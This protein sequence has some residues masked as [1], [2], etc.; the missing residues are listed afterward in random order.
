VAEAIHADLVIISRGH[1]HDTLGRLRTHAYE[2]I[3]E[4]ICPVLTL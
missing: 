3:W 2:V 4:S 1:M